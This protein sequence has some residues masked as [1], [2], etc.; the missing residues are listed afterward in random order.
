[1]EVL[2][3]T[4][5]TPSKPLPPAPTKM[6][7]PVELLEHVLSYLPV[8]DQ[9]L[10]ARTSRSL[11]DM[12]Y[13]DSRWIARLKSMGV[14]NED[15]A[16]SLAEEELVLSAEAE[17]KAREE[18]V[19]RRQV[20]FDAAIERK[21]FQGGDLLDLQVEE[22]FGEFQSVTMETAASPV[23]GM[24]PLKV[25]EG[26]VS[27]RGQARY[28]FGRVYEVL[29]PLYI[30]LGKANGLDDIPAFKHRQKLEEQ[31]SLLRVLELFGQARA[32]DNWEKCQKRIA[33]ITE[34][35]ERQM[36]TEFEEYDTC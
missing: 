9:L 4:V 2:T 27:R 13:D 34:T 21:K 10:F 1:M 26:V 16:K 7:L 32:V 24:S 31:G 12:V 15:E 29:A 35:F 5:L 17:K 6:A 8:P 33:W 19:L 20:V 30:A 3:P 23:E 18:A 11:R 25:L 22:A 36:I 28:E 14:W